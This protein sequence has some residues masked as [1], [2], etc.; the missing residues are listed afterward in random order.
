MTKELYTIIEQTN[1]VIQIQLTDKT[2]SIFL[3]HFPS[4]P[5]LP[6]F[7]Q[8]DIIAEILNDDIR[9]IISSKFI[10]HICP[11]DVINYEIKTKE[12]IKLIKIIKN[13]KKISEFKYETK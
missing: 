4:N 2:H 5:I 3:A 1:E 6:G 13:D 12:K 11:N 7:L 9:E 8:I 10:S